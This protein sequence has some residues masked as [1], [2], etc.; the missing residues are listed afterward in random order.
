MLKILTLITILL[1]V[2]V[3]SDLAYFQE[4]SSYLTKED[5]ECMKYFGIKKLFTDSLRDLTLIGKNMPTLP[6]VYLQIWGTS[7][8]PSANLAS[9]SSKYN[10]SQY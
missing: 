3:S 1:H 10:S 6:D 5:L 2:S 7:S 8:S 9:F 4:D